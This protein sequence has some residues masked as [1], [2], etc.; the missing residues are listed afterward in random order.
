M[1]EKKLCHFKNT[2]TGNRFSALIE[3][4]IPIS[5]LRSLINSLVIDELELANYDIINANSPEYAVPINETSAELFYRLNT[6]IFYIRPKN[7]IYINNSNSCAICYEN[8][9][10]NYL[11]NSNNNNNNWLC[12]HNNQ[13]CFNCVNLWRHFCTSNNR[14]FNCPLCRRN[15]N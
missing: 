11:N 6:D 5:N 8:F 15:I 2:D 7:S 4:N 10:P 12:N 1:V 9:N 13:C 14:I 3:T